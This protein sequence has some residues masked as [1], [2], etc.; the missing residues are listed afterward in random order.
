[1]GPYLAST[2]ATVASILPR[3]R[4][5]YKYVTGDIVVIN[6]LSKARA[7]SYFRHVC[8]ICGREFKRNKQAYAHLE[9]H[10]D[11]VIVKKIGAVDYLDK[12]TKILSDNIIG[13]SNRASSEAHEDERCRFVP[14]DATAKYIVR[15]TV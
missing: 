7:D 5:V 12:E 1:L 3:K 2:V 11:T 6:C 8:R 15:S 14:P 13:A 9:S 4:A 10:D